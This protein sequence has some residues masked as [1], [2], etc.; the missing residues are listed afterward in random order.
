M[1]HRNRYRCAATLNGV[2]DIPLVFEESDCADSER[3]VE[4][5]KE[6][7]GDPESERDRLVDVSP[8]YHVRDIATPV[9]VGYGTDDTRVD[10][11]HS[12]RL[13]LMLETLGMPHE[14]LEIQGAVHAPTQREWVIYARA[15]RRFLT[16]HLLPEQGFVDDPQPA[17]DGEFS[18]SAPPVLAASAP[19]SERRWGRTREKSTLSETDP[20]LAESISSSAARDARAEARRYARGSSVWTC[21]PSASIEATSSSKISCWPFSSPGG[22][23]RV[24]LIGST[25]ADF[26]PELNARPG[27]SSY[28]CLGA[29]EMHPVSRRPSPRK[30][31]RRNT[32][33]SSSCGSQGGC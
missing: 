33:V 30:P 18:A 4:R 22:T 1:R 15:L 24:S 8:A 3:C 31:T 32:R 10:P 26:M 27:A 17:D 20:E 7:I 21:N 19:S 16:K 5:W 2:S 12:Q 29:S 25:S 9:F 6:A 23:S 11:D 28:S 14:A 13:I